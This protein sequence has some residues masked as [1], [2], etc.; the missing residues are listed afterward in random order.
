MC[1]VQTPSETC[2]LFQ[3]ISD[4]APRPPFLPIRASLERR[5]LIVMWGRD[6]EMNNSES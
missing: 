2:T 4:P 3:H 1:V 6:D 5:E